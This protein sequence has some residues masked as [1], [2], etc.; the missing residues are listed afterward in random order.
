MIQKVV[1]RTSG[2]RLASSSAGPAT[3]T[4]PTSTIRMTENARITCFVVV[5]K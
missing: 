1:S 3:N 2:V 4:A 5:P